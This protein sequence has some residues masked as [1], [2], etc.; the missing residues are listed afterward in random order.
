MTKLY[1]GRLP[2]QATEADLMRIFSDFDA[3]LAE[4]VHDHFSGRPR[5]FG[6]VE[7]NGDALAAIKALNGSMLLGSEI[8]VAVAP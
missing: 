7:I 6:Y 3:R 4:V 2:R 5:G 8:V 1:V